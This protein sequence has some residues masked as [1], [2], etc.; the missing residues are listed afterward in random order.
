MIA[1]T[2]TKPALSTV[3]STPDRSLGCVSRSCIRVISAYQAARFGRVSPCR[4]YP[5]CSTYGIEAVETHGA[6]RGLLLSA[7]R[8]VRCRPGGPSGIDLV[9]LSSSKVHTHA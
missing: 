8:I 9:P 1:T 3:S 5:S 2:E 4:F 7:R 6:L